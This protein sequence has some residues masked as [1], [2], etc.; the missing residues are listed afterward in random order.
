M[1]KVDDYLKDLEDHLKDVIPND[2]FSIY[3]S[4]TLM[5]WEA[6]LDPPCAG[7]VYGGMTPDG[8][9]K[10]GIGQYLE[11]YVYVLAGS[12]AKLKTKST[13]ESEICEIIVSTT[14]FLD[15]MR[16][17]MRGK[18]AFSGKPW[19]FT[20]EQPFDFGKKGIGYIQTFKISVTT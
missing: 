9:D 13:K 7:V 1:L 20:G 14:S 12:N 19:I 10:R 3:D 18:C 8:N 5:D 2:I 17:T 11:F 4:E 16:S 15:T 6:K